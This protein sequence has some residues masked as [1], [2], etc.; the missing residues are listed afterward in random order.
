VHLSAGQ[1]QQ[2]NDNVYLDVWIYLQVVNC[3]DGTSRGILF[4]RP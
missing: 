1:R 3:Q 2:H 4:R